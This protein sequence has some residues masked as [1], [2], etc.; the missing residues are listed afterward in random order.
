MPGFVTRF[1]DRLHLVG[2]RPLD[3]K[4]S[5]NTWDNSDLPP[6]GLAMKKFY[7]LLLLALLFS[8]RTV[9][10]DILL[11]VEAPINSNIY[12]GVDGIYGWALA[13]SGIDRVEL[14]IDGVFQ[15]NLPYG[16]KRAG[17]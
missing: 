16:A 13:T 12:S 4:M 6:V 10:A 3:K 7:K 17:K 2:S 5:A 9:S 1:A 8:W 14:Y 15:E 11:T